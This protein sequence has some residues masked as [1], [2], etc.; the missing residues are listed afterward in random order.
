MSF[1]IV[2][3]LTAQNP[4]KR[5]GTPP[6]RGTRGGAGPALDA[7][8]RPIDEDAL[9]P[10]AASTTPCAAQASSAGSSAQGAAAAARAATQVAEEVQAQLDAGPSAQGAAAAAAAQAAARPD[11]AQV[12]EVG[13]RVYVDPRVSICFH[14]LQSLIPHLFSLFC[15][16]S[17]STRSVS[18]K[19]FLF[20]FSICMCCLVVLGAAQVPPASGAAAG[21]ADWNAAHGAAAW[22]N[23]R[24]TVTDHRLAAQDANPWA[25]FR[26]G[27]LRET[28][29][30]A[31][32]AGLVSAAPPG[33]PTGLPPSMAW[34]PIPPPGMNGVGWGMPALH[35]MLNNGRWDQA[36][37]YVVEE[38]CE[39]R[40]APGL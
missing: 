23:W 26:P 5:P 17:P 38:D 36:F 21:S 6:G 13:S 34:D 7:L 29:E 12:P 15:L 11:A 9:P 24:G 2:C 4:L 25:T 16:I 30:A 31:G 22:G 39:A 14:L 8:G 10:R 28:L 40:E 19:S 1:D 20:G 27:G 33:P 37:G 35:A 18:L 3:E 32:S